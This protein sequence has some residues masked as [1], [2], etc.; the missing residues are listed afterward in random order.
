ML[1]GQTGIVTIELVENA[2]KLAIWAKIG[3]KSRTA[4]QKYPNGLV[5]IALL[6]QILARRCTRTV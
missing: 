3:A 2:K 4:A 5:R 1:N 6:R